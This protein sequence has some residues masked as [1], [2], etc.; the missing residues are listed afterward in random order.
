MEWF[1]SQFPALAHTV[2]LDTA[3]LPPGL[4]PVLRAVEASLRTWEDGS[5]YWKDGEDEADRSRELFARLIGA[6][7]ANVALVCSLSEAAATVAQSIPAGEVVVGER[8]FRSNLFPWLALERRGCTIFQLPA[9][10]GVV[11]TQDF[12]DAIGPGTVLVSVSEVQS[13]TGFRV[14]LA[15]IAARSREVGARVFANLTQ[16]LG[17][18][19]FRVSDAGPDFVACHGYKWLLAPHGAAWLYVAEERL[20]EVEPLAPSWRSAPRSFDE[21][22]G[23]PI[24]LAPSARKLDTSISYLSSVGAVAAL[25]LLLSLDRE[26]VESTS[27]RLAKRFREGVIDLGLQPAPQEVPSQ[28]VGVRVPEVERLKAK[29]D[30]LRIRTSIRDSFLRVGFH[31]FNCDEDVDDILDALGSLEF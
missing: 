11:W 3:A 5:I 17:A 24:A 14:D 8:E 12:V 1:R 6:D 21:M 7:P 25:D 9:R 26:L 10:D 18:L 20:G 15:P 29:L 16:S 19:R 13:S 22:Y 30:D 31:G 4:L 28:I 27:L 2:W 23:G